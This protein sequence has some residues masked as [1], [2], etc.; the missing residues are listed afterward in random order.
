MTHCCKRWKTVQEDTM[1]YP[2]DC[3]IC[4]NTVLL[5]NSVD[6]FFYCLQQNFNDRVHYLFSQTN[7]IKLAQEEN[8]TKE[9]YSS[10]VTVILCCYFLGDVRTM[11]SNYFTTTKD[12]RV[13]R[14]ITARIAVFPQ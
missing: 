5:L 12:R 9:C 14:I 2:I 13:P 3:Q 8:K 6:L 4:L 10:Q 1:Q 7:L 11:A